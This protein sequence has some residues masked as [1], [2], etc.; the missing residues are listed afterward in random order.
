MASPHQI[1]ATARD[2]QFK[3]AG[4]GLFAQVLVV[5]K[6][7]VAI[8][9]A[10]EPGEADAIEKRIYERLGPH[11]YILR[12]FGEC[13]SIVGRGLALQYLPGG[14]LARN[15]ALGRFP[16]QRTDWPAQCVE[17]IRFIHSKGVIHCDVSANNFLIQNDGSL[18][19][20]DFC[21]SILD[22]SDALVSTSTRYTRPMSLEER[23]LNLTEKDDI[24][25][26]GTVLYEIVAGHFLYFDKTDGEIYTHFQKREFPDITSLGS[27]RFVVEKCWTD[28]YSNS[29]EIKLDLDSQV[30]SARRSFIEY[31]GL[32]FGM[33]LISIAIR[34]TGVTVL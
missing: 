11:P 18:A 24:F 17:A 26:L 20:A 6:T 22:G 28:Q 3:L 31:L 1:L 21:G 29:E 13:D 25:A 30:A 10:D 2:D 5:A 8:K 32:S 16:A 23:L 7:D 19:L 14:T 15:I 33:V 9:I 34:R 4:C 27:L 12:C